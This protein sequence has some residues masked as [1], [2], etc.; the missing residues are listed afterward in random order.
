MKLASSPSSVVIRAGW[1]SSSL[2]LRG[3]L[4][5]GSCAFAVYSS[6]ALGGGLGLRSRWLTAAI[7]RGFA[8]KAQSHE[9]TEAHLSEAH[10]VNWFV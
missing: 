2:M 1:P 6:V 4:N 5:C 7:A 10:G 8:S 3:V 9:K